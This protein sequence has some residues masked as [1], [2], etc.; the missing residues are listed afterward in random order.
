M[1]H[2]ACRDYHIA[3]CEVIKRENGD[4]EIVR[5]G[6]GRFQYDTYIFSF[7]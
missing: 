7:E 6:K 3:S 5:V 1:L 4:E 2:M